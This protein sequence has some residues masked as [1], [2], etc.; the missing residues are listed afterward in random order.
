MAD[1]LE[2]DVMDSRWAVPALVVG[3]SPCGLEALPGTGPVSP[4]LL[5]M[6]VQAGGLSMSYPTLLGC[7]I[8]LE[9][10]AERWQ[11]GP[12]LPRVLQGLRAMAEDPDEV[13]LQSQFPELKGAWG[14]WGE[15]YR[16]DVLQRL[17]RFL[18][19]A[20]PCP[21]LDEG[22]EAMVR[23]EPGDPLAWLR[24]V[25]L[26]ELRPGTEPGEG[27]TFDESVMTH[28]ALLGLEL[29][30]GAVRTYLVWTNSD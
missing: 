6:T 1:V 8:R 24:G 23:F 19:L 26:L 16:P 13:L 25:R 18:R 27:Q 21:G 22:L 14:T 28:L 10:N 2:L 12:G 3:F 4:W 7:L 15:A 20:L 5:R 29:N 11:P 9:Q 30:L 17:H